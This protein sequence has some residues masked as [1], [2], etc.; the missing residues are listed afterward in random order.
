M[1]LQDIFVEVQQGL[2]HQLLGLTLGEE[3]FVLLQ[4]AHAFTYLL[5]S[6][7]YAIER[8]YVVA[9]GLPDEIQHRDEILR[10]SNSLGERASTAPGHV[11][12]S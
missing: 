10:C 3:H 12:K 5:I 2:L 11:N 9:S 8:V 7:D 4:E 6:L 1:K